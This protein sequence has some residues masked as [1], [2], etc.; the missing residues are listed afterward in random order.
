MVRGEGEKE[1]ERE[2]RECRVMLTSFIAS[3]RV[4][5]FVLPPPVRC[6][7]GFAMLCLFAPGLLM[8]T[9]K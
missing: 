8:P 4:L 5:R 1:R 7:F 2:E 9:V 6:D 3:D